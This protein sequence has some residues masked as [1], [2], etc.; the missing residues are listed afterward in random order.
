MAYQFNAY[1]GHLN[2]PGIPAGPAAV[3]EEKGLKADV[4]WD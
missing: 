1:T 2:Q 4:F 3:Y